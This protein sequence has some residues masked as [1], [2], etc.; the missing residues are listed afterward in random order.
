MNQT[1]NIQSAA[2]MFFNRYPWQEAL[3]FF[4]AMQGYGAQ[5]ITN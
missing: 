3:K 5:K 4:G 2:S 1:G